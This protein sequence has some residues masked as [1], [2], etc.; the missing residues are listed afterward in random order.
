MINLLNNKYK[1]IDIIHLKE[2]NSTNTYCKK[3]AENDFH[4][5]ILVISDIQTQGKGTKGRPWMSSTNNGLW[6]SILLKP[7]IST[8]DINFLTILSS[9]ALHSALLNFNINT[10]IK[11]PN[12]L[13]LDNKKLSGILTEAKID[14]N[15]IVGIG[16]NLNLELDDF[17]DELKNKATSLYLSTGKKF[18][19]MKILEFFLEYFYKYLNEFLL[20]N[21]DYILEKYKSNSLIFNKEVTLFYKNSNKIIIPIDILKDGSLLVKNKN[22]ILENIIAGEISIIL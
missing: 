21:K 16:L 5:D 2:V 20:G 8:N 7:S 4:K 18:N 1:N 9:T 13:Y 11:W 10:K 15:I 3:I 22:D 19:S 12:D 14:N 17:N 6:F